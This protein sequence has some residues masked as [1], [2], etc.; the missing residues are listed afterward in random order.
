MSEESFASYFVDR[1][2]FERTM[3][4]HSAD[5]RVARVHN[6]MAERYEALALVFGAKRADEAPPYS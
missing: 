2:Q 4:Q 1:E 5:P 3:S 6:E